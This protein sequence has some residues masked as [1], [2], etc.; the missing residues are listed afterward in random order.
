MQWLVFGSS[1]L[2]FYLVNIVPYFLTVKLPLYCKLPELAD[3]DINDSRGKSLVIRFC[4]CQ[5]RSEFGQVHSRRYKIFQ[6][7]HLLEFSEKYWPISSGD[8][9]RSLNQWVVHYSCSVLILLSC[10]GATIF[11]R[12]DS[13]LDIFN[14]LTAPTIQSH[15]SSFK[16]LLLKNNGIT[17]NI[18]MKYKIRFIQRHFMFKISSLSQNLTQR[19]WPMTLIK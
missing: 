9:P 3:S 16:W 4:E 13:I 5:R 14:K 8:E 7:T 11:H 17:G 1:S 15:R 10:A 6:F 19:L 12:F 18:K 2:C